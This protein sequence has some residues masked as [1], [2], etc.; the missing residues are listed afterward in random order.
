MPCGFCSELAGM[1]VLHRSPLV[2]H[3]CPE[4]RYVVRGHNDE[5]VYSYVHVR[6]GRRDHLNF[7]R[8]DHEAKLGSNGCVGAD[9]LLRHWGME[10]EKPIIRPTYQ[11]KFQ[12]IGHTGLRENCECMP[13]QPD[14]LLCNEMIHA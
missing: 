2:R 7:G 10:R 4:Y 8:F 6:V 11:L 9:P 1:Q 14:E 3:S 5:P 12:C 13:M